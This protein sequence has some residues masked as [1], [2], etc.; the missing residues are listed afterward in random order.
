MNFLVSINF[1][2]A[3]LGLRGAGRGGA[4]GGMESDLSLLSVSKTHKWWERLQSFSV[5][6][7]QALYSSC[8][9]E[10]GLVFELPFA[11][12]C[13]YLKVRICVWGGRVA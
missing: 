10:Y 8:D 12:Q 9:W 5:G 13:S 7:S 4:G 3:R 1:Y 6:G 2:Q 11:K